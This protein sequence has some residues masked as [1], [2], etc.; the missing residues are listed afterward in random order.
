MERQTVVS[1]NLDEIGYDAARETLEIR[2]HSGSVYQYSP[3][4]QADYDAFM[5]AESKGKHFSKHFRN[6]FHGL[7][8]EEK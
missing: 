5:K 7:K 1:S 6:Y 3:V 2:F 4:K 8:I